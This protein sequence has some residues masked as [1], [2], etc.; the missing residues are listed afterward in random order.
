MPGEEKQQGYAFGSPITTP[1]LILR[2]ATPEDRAAMAALAANPQVAENLSADP[3]ALPG[4]SGE[5]FA[6][7]EKRSG[8][9]V[10]AASYGPMVDRRASLEVAAWIGQPWWGRGYATEA[11]HAVIDRAFADERINVLWC[12]NRA[13][14]FRARR[15]IEKC[16]FQFRETGMV[17]SPSLRGAMPVERFVLERRNWHSLKSWGSGPGSKGPRNAPRDNAA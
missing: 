3:C 9:V 6:V 12:S 14:N 17:R 4:E 2:P 16:G 13:S 11:T 1:R 10:G 7:V 15:V 8:T 5:T